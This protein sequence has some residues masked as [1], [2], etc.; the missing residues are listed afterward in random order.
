MAQN[1]MKNYSADVIL[2]STI[3]FISSTLNEIRF[4]I[5]CSMCILLHSVYIRP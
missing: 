2:I 4:A 5:D 1:E 3:I